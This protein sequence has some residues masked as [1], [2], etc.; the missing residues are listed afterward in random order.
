M[1]QRAR[2]WW[3]N[4]MDEVQRRFSRV[5]AVRK[6]NDLY[7]RD[8][9][10]LEEVNFRDRRDLAV[11]EI[12]RHI[13]PGGRVLDLGCGTGPVLCELLRQDIDCIGIDYSPDML[14]FAKRRL[15]SQALD[16]SRVLQGDC[17]RTPFSDKS[18]DAVICLGVIS[19]VENYEVVLEEIRR[20][21]KPGGL[22]LVSF[23]NR[24]NPL[25]S[26]PVVLVTRLIK[27]LLGRPEPER[28]EIGQFLDHRVF[29][30]KI[31]PLQ[32][33]FLGFRGIGFGPFRVGGRSLWTERQSVA[34][35]RRLAALLRTLRLTL[36]ERWLADVSVWIYR[37]PSERSL[38]QPGF[39][40]MNTAARPHGARRDHA[41]A[42][43]TVPCAI[44]RG[45]TSKGVFVQEVH[46]PQDP[47]RR[48]AA[49]IALMGSPDPRQVDGL[50]GADPLT[51]KAVIVARATRVGVDLEYESLEI[52]IG[53]SFVNHG[54]MCGNLTAAVAYFAMLEGLLP[55][56]APL[57]EV[58]MLCRN[59]GK[60]IVCRL[61]AQEPGV[62]SGADGSN[63]YLAEAAKTVS[64]VFEQ[65]AGAVTGQ[66]LP[67]GEPVSTVELDDGSAVPIS[68]VDAGALYAFLRAR[69]LGVSGAETAAVLDA[70]LPFR[71]AVEAIRV[72]ITRLLN[73]R[74]R[75]TQPLSP[76]RLKIAIVAE[77]SDPQSGSDVLARVINPARVHKAYAVGGAISLGCAAAIPGTLVNTLA[78]AGCSPFTLR[79]GH[80]T[81]VLPVMIHHATDPTGHRILGAEIQ[82]SVRIL[83]RGEAYLPVPQ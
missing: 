45:G 36:L 82:R 20:I 68:V 17:R 47:A 83:M 61:P 4:R 60:T 55:G 58:R 81:G 40:N 26:D 3:S 42:M 22:L 10:V 67:T 28:Y 54:I 70:N 38:G 13:S 52:A 62:D 1:R 65:P 64:L 51:S 21:L 16:A 30:R 9:S 72:R 69:D 48:D 6:W 53:E 19:Y 7:S 24:F 25:L 12:A 35:S 32:F 8:T 73:E 23:R 78:Q 57:S 50:G 43:A 33:R 15:R 76:R 71:S 77:S 59:S 18:F 2:Q 75:L 5:D 44:I 56:R 14:E 31:A 80:P 79:I 39:K 29:R 27:R 63:P 37:A 49:L 41:G 74:L 46:L 11:N 66:L 34:L